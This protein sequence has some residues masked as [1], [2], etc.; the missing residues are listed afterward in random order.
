MEFVLERYRYAALHANKSS[1]TTAPNIAFSLEDK[2]LQ[3]RLLSNFFTGSSILK[4]DK[5]QF[6][7]LLN[8]WYG[9]QKQN[10]HLI[11][12]ASAHAFSATMFHQ[13]CDGLAPLYVIALVS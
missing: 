6:Q 11:F 5:V 4:N 12:R 10:W 9:V 3:P 2:R 8:D 13:F 1:V 7:L